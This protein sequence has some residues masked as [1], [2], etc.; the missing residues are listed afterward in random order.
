VVALTGDHSFWI[1]K[2]VGLDEEFKRYAVPFFL[3]VPERLQPKKY[4]LDNFGSHEDIFPTLYHL[5]LSNQEY[6]KLG[7]DLIGEQSISQNSSGLVADKNGA[8][9]NGK[10]WTWKSKADLIL[11]QTIETPE[12][13]NLKNKGK[14]LIGLT[15]LYLKD[16][17]ARKGK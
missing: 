14:S 4:D 11:Q 1:A 9:H 2:G 5:T 17:K 6:L 3:S 10:Y 16:E 8:F 13:L 7:D 12:L 15:D